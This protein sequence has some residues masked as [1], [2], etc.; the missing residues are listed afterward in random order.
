MVVGGRCSSVQP[1]ERV[2]TLNKL[3]SLRIKHKSNETQ[4]F[5]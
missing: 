4:F 2:N 1:D 5:T 3:N